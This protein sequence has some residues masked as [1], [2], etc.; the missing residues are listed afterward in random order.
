MSFS[1]SFDE[2]D[3]LFYF[4]VNKFNDARGTSSVGDT[5]D[6]SQPTART[7]RRREHSRNLKLD[8]YVQQNGK[9]PISIVPR[10]DK[11]ISPHAIIF[12]CTI[13]EL[14]RDTFPGHALKWTGTTP[15]YIKLVKDSL[16]QWFMLDFT[17]PTLTR[18]VEYQMRT[19][20]EFKGQNHRHFKKFSDPEQA[21]ANP[22]SIL[23][24]RV[25]DWHFLCDHYLT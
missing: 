22:P 17:D 2:S 16:Q 14:T 12:S 3:A 4:N 18:F 6:G 9:I 23:K 24:N 11:P 13:V 5:S 15:E 21:R 1:A 8:R 25:E 7:P 19:W 20:K 10:K